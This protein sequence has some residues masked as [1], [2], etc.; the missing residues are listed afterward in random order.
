MPESAAVPASGTVHWI[1]TGL[2]TGSGLSVLIDRA[3]RP[4]DTI[5]WG[6]TEAKAAACLARLGRTGRASTDAYTPEALANRV[7]PGDVVIS[8]LPATKHLSLLRLCV[9]RRAHF[10]CTSYVSDEILGEAPAAE[11]AGI[12]VLTEAGLDPGIDHVL[13]ERLV[14]RATSAID[15]PA[16]VTFFS[17]CGGIP[18]EPNA[19]RYRFSWAPR[20][21]LTALLNPARYVADGREVVAERPWEAIE[22]LA[23]EG[24]TFEVYP[25]RDS[26]PF[27]AQYRFPDD[28][29]VEGFV[30]GTLRLEGWR[31]AWKGVFDELIAG[32][33]DRI[34]ALARELAERYPTTEEDRDRVV[35]A[36]G[37]EAHT[38]GGGKHWTGIYMLDLVGDAEESA[39]A[40]CVSLPLAFGVYEILDGLAE[41]GLRRAGH[42]A[43]SADRWLAG[44][45]EHGIEC[46]WMGPGEG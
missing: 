11:Q 33:M 21:V 42:D 35:L 41:P 28:W 18:A 24:E 4:E 6:R 37:L 7:Q 5:V 17:Y 12:V 38:K 34:D 9:E 15:G 1:G 25:N 22:P 2:S 20:G 46:T 30:R 14:A 13:A 19:F 45:R 40:K 29:R 44:L 43:A 39:M 26:V 10:A 27:I 31:E 32:D 23:L 16:E 8:M 36:V 3:A